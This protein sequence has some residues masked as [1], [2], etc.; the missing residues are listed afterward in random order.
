MDKNEY[1]FLFGQIVKI[2]SGKKQNLDEIELKLRH[3][4]NGAP[5]SYSDLE[6]IADEKYWPF[7][8]YWMWPC[9]CQIENKLPNTEGWFNKLP[10]D[11]EK[12][13]ADLNK[14]F[15][16]IALVSIVLRFSIPKEYAIYSSPPLNILR[17]ERGISEVEEYLTYVN[18]M[19]ILRKSFGVEKTSEV[20]MI[21]W[22]IFHAKGR[23]VYELKKILSESLPENLSPEE[24]VIYLSYDPLRVAKAYLKANDHM[25]AGFWA[26]KAFEKFLE[27]E[28]R[29]NAIY[30][31]E[32]AHKRS[33]MIKRLCDETFHW[34]K[35]QNKDLLYETKD[36]RNKIVPGVKDFASCDVDGFI[37]N[38]E[39]LKAIATKKGH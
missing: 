21:V 3:L 25:T 17:I 26:A 37:N 14:I 22:A 30:V 31:H 34:K 33:L 18:E 8:K 11:E 28:C 12:I 10:S 24:L 1:R 20:D 29:N 32:Q 5:L 9:R 7:K 2:P 13:I 36:I 16:N 38:I 35:L 15:M 4:K 19:R 23:Y 27:Y 6:I 39:V